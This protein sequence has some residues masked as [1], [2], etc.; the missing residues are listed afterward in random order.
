M[1]SYSMLIS[2][3]IFYIKENKSLLK[4]LLLF[5][6]LD[7][8]SIVVSILLSFWLLSSEIFLYS[9]SDLYLLILIQ[10]FI[11]I[12]VYIFT[13]QYKA[14]TKY[15]GSQSLYILVVRNGFFIAICYFL[16]T[17]LDFNPNKDKFWILLWLLVS[18]FTGSYRLFLRDLLIRYLA[19]TRNIKTTRVAIYGAGEIGA[20]LVLSLKKSAN[21]SLRYIFDDDPKLWGRTLNSVSIFPPQSIKD[22]SG[23]IDQVL[24]TIKSINRKRR[25]QIVDQFQMYDVPVLSVPSVD[26]LT[27]GKARIDDINPIRIEDLLGR[28]SVPPDPSLLGPGIT[29]K[30][31]CVTGAGGSIGSEL[32][33]Q[34]IKFKPSTLILLDRNEPSL[35]EIQ[36]EISRD[37]PDGVNLI[38]ALGSANDLVRIEKL[39]KREKTE[40]VFHAAAYKHVP[41][42]EDNPLQGIVNNALTTKTLCEAS[43]RAGVKKFCLISTDK[44]VRPTN[45]MGASKRLSELIVQA[46]HSEVSNKAIEKNNPFTCFS[47]VRFGNVLGS[48]GS[49][50]PLFRKQ[51]ASGGPITITHPKI[52]RY[53]M[54][55][56]EAA[57]LVLQSSM[58]AEGGEVFLLDMG[59]PVLIINLAKEMIRLSGLTLKDSFNPEGDIEIVYT[60]LR[61]GEKLFEELLIDGESIPTKHPLIFKAIEESINPN[62]LWKEIDSLVDAIQ[63]YDEETSLTL[64]S[65]LIPEW[66]RGK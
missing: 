57:Q 7:S 39:F 14:L 31:V 63:K 18:L 56:N 25:R 64:L 27:S 19:K 16:S 55:V 38:F 6:C 40:I 52:I 2:K 61:L 3:I 13:G 43:L 48:S 8:L 28:N 4:R 1:K 44:A 11:G 29:A 66:K 62:D 23:E 59:D 32:I 53:F 47:M 12:I 45:V 54:T 21:Y 58:L 22:L 17:A 24:I 20:N 37:L 15:V 5:G 49:V 26:D 30:S 36:Q 51:I 9:G 50:V 34:I 65:K 42:V 35:Y 60:G 10:L 46:F 33:R 41:L